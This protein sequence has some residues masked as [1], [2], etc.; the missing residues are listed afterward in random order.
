MQSQWE[1]CLLMD[2]S[3]SRHLKKFCFCFNSLIPPVLCRAGLK[4]LVSV[5]ERFCSSN[6]FCIIYCKWLLF[7]AHT[8][9][10]WVKGFFS[11]SYQTI[12]FILWQFGAGSARY[13]SIIGL[14]SLALK[15]GFSKLIGYCSYRLKRFK[16]K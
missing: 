2:I 10:V 8:L 3:F 1:C 5:E 14:I 12:C 15:L 4:C 6:C 13:A 9:M 11:C 7:T 16:W